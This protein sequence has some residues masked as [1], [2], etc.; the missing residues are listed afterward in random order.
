MTGDAG[1]Q[2]AGRARSPVT[3]IGTGTMGSAL[4]RA[5]LAAGHPVTAWNRTPT[6]AAPLASAGASIVNDPAV[7]VQASDLV[8]MCVSDQAAADALLSGGS[9]ADLLRDPTLVQL[10]TGT[11]ADGPPTP[12]W[13][14]PR[15]IGLVGAG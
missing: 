14:G 6:R 12:S 13:T 7:A 4:A 2:D 1:Q 5:L 9:L 10:R 11:A 3:V 15:G 8:L